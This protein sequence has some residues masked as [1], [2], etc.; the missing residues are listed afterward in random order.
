M[1]RPASRRSRRGRRKVM[2]FV[3]SKAFPFAGR[4]AALKLALLALV[5]LAVLCTFRAANASGDGDEKEKAGGQQSDYAQQVAKTY[6]FR[7][8]PNPF[9]PSNSSST[10]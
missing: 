3:M 4:P 8:G 2:R 5:A 1:S 9:A 6:D 10:T 7:F